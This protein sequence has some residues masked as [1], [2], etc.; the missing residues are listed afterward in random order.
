MS[1]V[2]SAPL[3]AAVAWLALTALT[4]PQPAEGTAVGGRQW[5]T[6]E[7]GIVGSLHGVS[8]ASA[9]DAW[10]VG[11]YY[12]ARGHENNLIEHWDGHDEVILMPSRVVVRAHCP[13]V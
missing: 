13:R 1:H 2:G 6:S 12:N 9:Q 7:H 10:A 11:T 5:A 4:G 8:A 3:L